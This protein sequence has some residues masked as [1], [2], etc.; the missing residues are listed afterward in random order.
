MNKFICMVGLPASGK[1]TYAQILSDQY[2]AIIC[3]SDRIREELFNDVNDQ[4]HNADVFK[5]LYKRIKDG[6]Q[7]GQNVIMDSTNISYKRRMAFIQELKNI[8]CEKI[9]VLMA[10]PYKECLKNNANRDRVVPEEVI[11]RMYKN[12]N[13]PFFY[14]GWNQIIVEY[15]KSEYHGYYGYPT[16]LMELTMNFDQN[17]KHHT[18]SLGEHLRSTAHNLPCYHNEGFDI[19]EYAL[20]IAAILHDGG[21]IF[22]KDFHNGKGEPTEDAHYFNHNN[23]GAYDSLFYTDKMIG[24]NDSWVW[25]YISILIMWHMQPYFWEKDN[26]EKLHNKYRKLWGEELYADIMKLHTADKNAH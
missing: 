23:V 13:I 17:N 4:S 20:I 5:E 9:C 16:S 7:N 6:L 15:G 22:T 2:N 26:N 25:L 11:E 12:F 3:S 24:S 1:S 14:E 8:P 10:T 19:Y 18:L 21:K